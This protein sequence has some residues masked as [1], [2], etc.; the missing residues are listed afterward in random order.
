[1]TDGDLTCFR[2][3]FSSFCRS[4]YLDDEND[5]RNISLKETHTHH[6][7]ENIIALAR[8]ESLDA[9][10]VKIAEAVGLFHDVGRFP[11]YSKYRTFSDA[12]SVNHGLLG[13]TVLQEQ[14]LLERLPEPERD[15]IIGAVKFHNA[16]AIADIADAR[17]IL[18]LKL[19]RDADKLD[20]W[21]VFIEYY[22]APENERAGAVALGL[23]DLPTCSPEI[24]SSIHK[25]EV[26]SLAG[27]K[28]LNDFKLL[29][30][31]WIFDLNFRTSFRLLLER[32]Y[33]SR[34]AA[35]LPQNDDVLASVADIRAYAQER[36]GNG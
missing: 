10:G 30:L 1:M 26:V 9:N 36:A 32:D 2:D 6:V 28:T 33:I 17:T 34:I 22:E 31:S 12:I 3:W 29:Q 7:R 19:V 23:P 18:F 27:L 8:G 16:F 4:Y 11:Q 25:R 20:I 5:Q 35:T 13:A 14:R 21:R 15:I 24:F